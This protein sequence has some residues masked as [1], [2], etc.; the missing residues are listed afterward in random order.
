GARPARERMQAILE[1]ARA[2]VAAEAILARRDRIPNLI[3]AHNELVALAGQAPLYNF[4]PG[5]LAMEIGTL[6]AS[7]APAS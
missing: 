4:D 6:L 1:L 2:I 5:L 7:A 3:R